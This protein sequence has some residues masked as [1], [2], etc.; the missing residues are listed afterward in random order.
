MTCR[1]FFFRNKGNVEMKVK[2][3]HEETGT[4]PQGL[5]VGEIR[6]GGG[7][8]SVKILNCLRECISYPLL[9]NKLIQNSVADDNTH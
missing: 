8:R 3:Y 7:E 1:F 6:L 2:G 5:K 4:I 9:L